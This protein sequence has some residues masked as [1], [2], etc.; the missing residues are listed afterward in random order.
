MLRICDAGVLP[1]ARFLLFINSAF[2]TESAHNVCSGGGHGVNRVTAATL[3]VAL[4]I[5]FGDI[6]TSPLYVMKAIAGVN[7]AWN[8][9]YILGAVSCVIWTLTL[10]TTLK[11]VVIAL[12]ADNKGE[13]GILA[14]YALVKRSGPAWL[15][16]LAALGA[17]A[18]VADGV[19]T[20]AITVT[21]AIE[22]L[23]AVSPSAPVIPIV[24][25]I[26]TLIFLVQQFGTSAIGKGFGPFMLL[27]FLMLGIVGAMNLHHDLSVLRA[28]NP[29]YAVKLLVG[30]PEWFLILGAVFLCTTGAEALYSD[31]G[32]CGRRN[33]T[34]T[35]A[36]VKTMLILNY[37]GQGAWMISRGPEGMA[38][39]VN[40]FFAVMPGGMLVPGI[41]MSTGAAIIASQALLSGAFTIFGEAMN[42]NLSPGLRIKYPTRLKGQLYIPSVNLALYI[43][44]IV[45]VFI[46]GSSAGMEAAY[47]LAITVTMLMTTVLLVFYM[48][49]RRTATA[50]IVLFAAVFILIEGAFFAA[51]LSKFVHGG[52]YTV[53]L[54]GIIFAV[55][56]VWYRAIM[57]RNRYIEY[58]RL[59]D[60][61]PLIDDIKHDSTIPPFASNLVYLSKSP[62]PGMVESKLIYSIVNKG[63]KRADHYWL[64][65]I[66]RCDDP[67]TLTYSYT[68]P[69]PGTVICVTLRVG[70]RIQPRIGTYLR[71]IVEDMTARGEISLTSTHP[72]LAARGIPGNFRFVLIHRVF[73]P[74]S[75]CRRRD[76]IIMN[77]HSVL[78][79]AGVSDET[80]YGLDTSVV[81]VE[82][83]PLIIDNRSGRR[84]IP[85]DE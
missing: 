7:P 42:L 14:L 26:I 44:C 75:N 13:G 21:S 60:S 16:I 47:G 61:L 85:V 73:S 25:V 64:L 48:R 54:G 5:V 62:V 12:R 52:W 32:H 83:V 30:S 49:M 80:A 2:M 33:I 36:F 39:G 4:G 72:S 84:V 46:F 34:L 77:M 70:F 63:P 56:T 81:A 28:F 18:L 78:R 40:P 41:I 76:T 51:N 71:Q 68:M 24:I 27:W 50:L 6:G 23:R 22:G 8:A 55:M 82:T 74:E 29:W 35:W 11:Y 31:L 20:P 66:E 15:Y 37:L 53:A 43:G 3:L 59:D 1:G 17:A 67:D 9:D 58:V 69:V 79:R 65:R 45:T 57:T 38:A 19:I 10:Q